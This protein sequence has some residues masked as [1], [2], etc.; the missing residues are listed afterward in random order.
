MANVVAKL[1]KKMPLGYAAGVQI[2]AE[3]AIFI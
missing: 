1:N 2:K 3:L